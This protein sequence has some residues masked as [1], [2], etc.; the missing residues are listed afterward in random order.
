M[1]DYQQVSIVTAGE[2]LN[3]IHAGI[4]SK[5]RSTVQ[6]AI[7]A[8]EILAQVKERLPHGDFLPWIKLNC[9]FSQ[10]SASNY[11][12]LFEY[13]SKL[14][15]VSNLQEA[16]RQVETLEAQERKTDDQKA[17]E[18]VAT[19]VKTGNKPEGWRRGTDDK[20]AQEEIERDKRIKAE[21]E[22]IKLESAKKEQTAQESKQEYDRLFN[23][24]MKYVENATTSITKRMAFKERIRLSH[25]GVNDS[26]IDALMDYLDELDDDSRRIEA[27]YNIIKVCKGI[28]NDLQAGRK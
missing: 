5:M 8:G 1:S 2:E 25:E 27:C 3:R 22:R 24:A 18:R 15:T 23:D 17:R 20:L 10:Q 7:R 4:E 19:F 28:A 16:Y 21:Q 6:D 13:R 14:P 9:R 12:R 11:M 26:F